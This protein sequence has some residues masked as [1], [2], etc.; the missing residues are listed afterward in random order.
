MFFYYKNA[1]P[2]AQP[3]AQLTP[4]KRNIPPSN[5]YHLPLSYFRYFE[6]RIQAILI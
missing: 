4:K 2:N 6:R 5:E 1:Q 3:N